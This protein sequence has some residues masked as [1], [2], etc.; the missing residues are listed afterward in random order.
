MKLVQLTNRIYYNPHQPETDRP[1]QAY[2][3]G[4]KVSLAIDAGYSARH[5]DEF[6]ESLTEY[7][8]NLPDFTVL[9]HWHYDHTFG[10]HRIHGLSVA[11][12]KTNE[13]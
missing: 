3:K 13:Y 1:M 11:Y 7:G 8:L 4:N 6:Y 5:V 10:M 12:E 2:L 9:T